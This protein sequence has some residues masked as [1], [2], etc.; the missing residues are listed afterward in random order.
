MVRSAFWVLSQL[1]FFSLLTFSCGIAFGDGSGDDCSES[2]SSH[3]VVNRKIGEP[4]NSVR[5]RLMHKLGKCSP[6][7]NA[8]STWESTISEMIKADAKRYNRIE[9]SMAGSHSTK[10]NQVED[11]QIPLASGK[12]AINAGGNYIIQIAFGTPGQSQYTLIDTGSDVNWIPC[13]PCVGCNSNA[14]A[15]FDSSKSSSYELL[16]CASA[17]CTQ[18]PASFRICSG[19][20]NCNFRLGYGDQSEV[21]GLL[22]SDEL[23]LGS[24]S[25]SKLYF[26]CANVQTGNIRSE[27]GLIGL[28]KGA[29]SFLSQTASIYDNTFSYC[30][31]SLASDKFSGSLVFGKEALSAQ[32]LLSLPPET[33]A[34]DTSTGSGGAI[35]DSGTVITR[36]VE[37]AYTALRDA[38]RSKLSNLMDKSTSF[39]TFFDTCYNVV[40]PA[41]IN[42]PTITF[43]SE[44]GLDLELSQE[45]ILYQQDDN[46]PVCLAFALPP[47]GLS[48][49]SIFGNFQQQNWRIIYDVPHSQLGFAQERCSA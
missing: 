10:T 34:L 3:K 38:F 25:I 2:F 33:F 26:G 37:P 9:D 14:A 46:S 29:L 32:E 17:P 31:P 41:S 4:S 1:L 5:F 15:P 6:F 20:S 11:S 22:S 40:S 13:N 39:G 44:G 19:N 49:L 42:G 30:L 8:N 35:I 48:N 18:L 43:H 36:L 7:R 28:G 23:T 12:G 45:N 27:P 21:D 24:E 16:G 47:K